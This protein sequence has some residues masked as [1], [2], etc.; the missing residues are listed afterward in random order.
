[1]GVFIDEQEAAWV[2]SASLHRVLKYNLD[3]ELQHSWGVYGGPGGLAGGLFRPHQIDVDQEGNV[4]VASWS[5]GWVN[6]FTP[7][8]DADPDKLTF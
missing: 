5:G 3:G 4:Y 7:K 6:K 1:M 2:I 8:P